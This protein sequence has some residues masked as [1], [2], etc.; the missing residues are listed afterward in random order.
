MDLSDKEWNIVRTVLIIALLVSGVFVFS[1]KNYLNKKNFVNEFD[2]SSRSIQIE[3]QGSDGRFYP[4]GTINLDTGMTIRGDA[5]GQP[6]F[7]VKLNPVVIANRITLLRQINATCQE[8]QAVNLSLDAA[9]AI[10]PWEKTFVCGDKNWRLSLVST[11]ETRRPPVAG[12]GEML[13]G[14]PTESGKK[15]K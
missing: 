6:T 8:K 15:A 1:A 12:P 2:W 9:T 10:K 7:E 5:A 3:R 13:P 4:L 14:A 11:S